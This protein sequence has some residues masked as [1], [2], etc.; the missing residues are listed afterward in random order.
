M[1]TV[2]TP[3]SQSQSEL[4][5]QSQS[6]SQSQSQALQQSHDHFAN[7]WRSVIVDWSLDLCTLCVPPYRPF[8]NPNHIIAR[9]LHLTMPWGWFDVTC[10][11]LRINWQPIVDRSTGP[12]QTTTCLQSR[13]QPQSQSQ[14]QSLSLSESALFC[15][16]Q[17]QVIVCDIRRSLVVTCICL[18]RD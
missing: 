11:L 15:V 7:L 13:S 6:Q 14:S 16:L 12:I 8:A 1:R 3:Q 9:E 4:Q 18:N 2:A 17:S 5:T 10:F